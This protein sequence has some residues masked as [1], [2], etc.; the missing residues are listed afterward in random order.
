VTAASRQETRGVDGLF[1]DVEGAAK[2]LVLPGGCAPERKSRVLELELGS[3]N[4]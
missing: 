4:S 3:V 1:K 2:T